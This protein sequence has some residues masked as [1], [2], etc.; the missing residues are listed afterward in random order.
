MLTSLHIK[1]F[2]LIEKLDLDFNEGFC[3]ITGE[4]GAGKSILLDSIL[5]CFGGKTSTSLVRP[6]ADSCS[7]AISF[8]SSDAAAKYLSDIEIEAGSEIVIKR[9]QNVQGRKKF[10]IN[11]QLVSAKATGQLF[12]CL[13]EL[14]GQHNHTKLVTPAAHLEI[15]DEYGG[16]SAELRELAGSY[17]NWQDLEK[18]IKQLAKDREALAEEIEYLAHSCEELQKSQVQLGEE[19]SLADMKRK[20]QNR[21][22]EIAKI[23]DILR[24]L[25]SSS[26]EQ[27]VARSQRSIDSFGEHDLLEKVNSNL[28]IMYDKIEDS[29]TILTQI[30]QE[31]QNIDQSAEEVNDRLYEIRTLARKH[32]CAPDDLPDF[33]AKSEEQLERLEARLANSANT[34]NQ[35]KQ[36]KVLYFEQATSLSQK[37]SAAAR[38]LAEKTTKE[39]GSL[40]MKKAIFKVEVNSPG[41][42]GA[43]GAS[44]KVATLKGID[45]VRFIASTNPGMA[46]EPIDK[47]ASG[48]ELSRFM[49]ALRVALF[50]KAAKQTIIFDE[51]DVGISGS[52]ADSMGERLK[53]LSS[54]VQIIIITHQPQVA[55]KADQH[56]LVEKTQHDTHTS[57]VAGNLGA[58]GRSLEL[59][60]MI[61]G[62]RITKT[63]I[64]AAKELII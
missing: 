61:S 22:Q 34:Q 32:S 4:T 13:L 43:P 25:D 24:D 10:F 18:E 1:D 19:D 27:I 28:E 3:V 55:G 14:H 54:V 7:V 36:A 12:G 15:L 30:L 56:I 64:E 53:L 59:A 49:L 40:E 9:V 58:E 60:R 44:E 17:R 31:F 42:P 50:D 45:S 26:I 38:E 57:V 11:D 33:L 2:I 20:L 23:N 8:A 21:D 6:G 47:I 35:A 41:A 16:F 48:G 46:P 29:K 5:F 62:K 63:S 39:L 52:V 37:R 51:I